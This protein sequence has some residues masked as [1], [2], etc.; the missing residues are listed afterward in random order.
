MG[1]K[2]PNVSLPL[3]LQS[4]HH[5]PI[6][7]QESGIPNLQKAAFLQFKAEKTRD[8]SEDKQVQDPH[9]TYLMHKVEKCGLTNS[10]VNWIYNRLNN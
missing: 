9:S 5:V 1:E 4:S 6:G 3:A 10:I 8:R 7:Y 2:Y